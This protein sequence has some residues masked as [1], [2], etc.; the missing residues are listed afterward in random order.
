MI[1]RETIASGKDNEVYILCTFEN[2]SLWKF[3]L[4]GNKWEQLEPT[5]GWLEETFMKFLEENE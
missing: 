2:G 1:S 4:N 5:T 3:I